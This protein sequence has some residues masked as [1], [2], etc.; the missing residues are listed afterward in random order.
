M[1]N[2]QAKASRP[3]TIG[4]GN[5]L[6]NRWVGGA[7][8]MRV[9]DS[10]ETVQM[11]SIVNHR[12][13]VEP[14]P[15]VARL[16]RH[17]LDTRI[18]DGQLRSGDRNNPASGTFQTEQTRYPWQNRCPVGAGGGTERRKHGIKLR[19]TSGLNAMGGQVF[20][21]FPPPDVLSIERCQS[22]RRKIYHSRGKRQD[23]PDPYQPI[24][25]IL[26]KKSLS[27]IPP[28][29]T[30]KRNARPF[31][32]RGRSP[33]GGKGRALRFSRPPT[34]LIPRGNGSVPS[35]VRLCG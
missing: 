14:L 27:S 22:Q 16:H 11:P 12:N 26:C 34:L 19:Q 2:W 9:H 31:P 20:L 17:W 18:I 28:G 4:H 5:G 21:A 1:S 10:T 23:T 13:A 3:Y 25:N 6:P 30:P 29:A 8:G 35:R 33:S 7:T 15:H 32:E 24:F